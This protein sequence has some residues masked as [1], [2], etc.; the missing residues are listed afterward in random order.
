MSEL[1]Q[2]QDRSGN[3]LTEGTSYRDLYC[4]LRWLDAQDATLDAYYV[5]V[6]EFDGS[7][8]RYLPKEVLR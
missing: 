5:E 3:R 6:Y 1:W 8:I 7:P 2:L 4:L